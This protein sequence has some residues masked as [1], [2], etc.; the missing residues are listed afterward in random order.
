MRKQKL[1]ASFRLSGRRLSRVLG[2]LEAD[3]MKVLWRRSPSSIREV[4]DEIKS[5]RPIAFNTVMTVMNRLVD[6]GL[7][8][9]EDRRGSYRYTPRVSQE[10]FLARVSHDVAETLIHEFGEIAVAQFLE[11]LQEVDPEKLV[12]LERL[13]R[14]RRR[15]QS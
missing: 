2:D 10:V 8:R 15:D 13:I 9:R 5:K 7:L 3:V 1:I 11:V 14:E 12:A 4:W 6:K